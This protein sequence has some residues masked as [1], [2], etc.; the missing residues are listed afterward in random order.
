MIP[1][2]SREAMAAL[3]SDDKRFSFWLEIELL[4][5]E[6]CAHHGLLP[7]EVARRIRKRARFD[8]KRVHALEAESKHDVLAFLASVGESLGDDSAY[9][10]RGLTSS[11]VIDTA[12]SLQ[13]VAAADVLLAGLKR[14]C[15]GLEKQAWRYKDVLCMGRSHGMWAE[16]TSFGLKM[17]YAWAEFQRNIQRLQT[18]QEDVRVCALSGPVGTYA[19]LAPEIEAFV[20]ERL[21]LRVE[22]VSTQIIPRDRHALFFCVL[23]VIA[24]SV[25]RLAT[26]V[27]H[28]QRSEVAEAAEPFAHG[29]KGSSAMPHKRNPILSENVSG[30]GRLVRSYVP[31]ALDNVVLWHER[32]ISHSS[33]ERVIAPD[34]TIA[35]DFAVHR[36]THIIEGLVVDADKMA[37]HIAQSGGLYG[38]SKVLVALMEQ[39]VAREQAYSAVQQAALKCYQGKTPSFMQGLQDDSVVNK[40]LTAEQLKALLEPQDYV[41]HLGTIYQRVFNKKID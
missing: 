4:A 39:G 3:W 29:Q 20:A 37:H 6:A 5:C 28:L 36:L 7:P 18:A 17:A 34:A 12:F 15:D 41:K 13:L 11:D 32:D 22:T 40:A 30:L 26:E 9:L 8:T 33:V 2:Y 25:D 35:L 14:L 16:P 38:S 31:A 19:H 10:H 27:R 21:N 24:A 23:G 1:R